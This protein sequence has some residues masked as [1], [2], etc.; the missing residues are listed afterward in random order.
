MTQ[1]AKRLSAS[2]IQYV[3]CSILT[4]HVGL[5][6]KLSHTNIYLSYFFVFTPQIDLKLL[7]GTDVSLLS[8]SILHNIYQEQINVT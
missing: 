5:N 2:E 3:L 7:E 1:C 8:H 6:H 4:T